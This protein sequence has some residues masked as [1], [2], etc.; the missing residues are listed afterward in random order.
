MSIA[1]LLQDM[2]F[3]GTVLGPTLW[4]LFFEDARTALNEWF[5]EEV[6]FADDMS[7][8]RV[9]MPDTC[10]ETIMKT[11]KSVQH[12]LHTWG[13]ANQVDF[14]AKKE[15]AHIL[16]L[17]EPVGDSFKLLGVTFDVALTMSDAVAE[18]VTAAS[19]K[20]RTL[21][22]TRRYYTDAELIVL[23]KAHLLSFLEYRTSAIYHAP[24][25]FLARL[26]AIQT[27][28]LRDAGVSELAA[29]MEFNLAP[30]GLRRDIAM[31]GLLHRAALKQG[32]PHLQ[33]MFKRRPG[34]FMLEDPHS[35]SGRQHS[36]LRRSAWGLIPVYNRLGSGAQCILQ[37]RD[38]QY[39]LQERVKNLVTKHGVVDWQSSYSPR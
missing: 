31:L 23:Y 4:N 30:L 14:D 17:T 1:M 37:V 39:Y 7:A 38:F 12:E 2:V 3:Q 10:N 8:Y 19:W 27:R 11:I 32:P 18:V 36:S 28:F 5:F 29:L 26:D 35:N 33:G 34:S 9:F 16:S 21:L 22:R 25:A 15:S 20:L 24:R 13:R 6:V